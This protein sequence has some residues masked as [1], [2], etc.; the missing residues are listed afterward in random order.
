MGCQKGEQMSE[1]LSGQEGFRDSGGSSCG[2]EKRGNSSLP[3]FPRQKAGWKGLAEGDSRCKDVGERADFAEK[4][5]LRQSV[6][7]I[8]R[9]IAK[10]GLFDGESLLLLLKFEDKL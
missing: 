6:R 1:A 9:R 2:T 5:F 4:P 7:G 3:A 10:T 8:R